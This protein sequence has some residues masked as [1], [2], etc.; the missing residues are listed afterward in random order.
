MHEAGLTLVP[1]P[2]GQKPPAGCPAGL[3]PPAA[4]CW[5][6]TNWVFHWVSVKWANELGVNVC[7]QVVCLKKFYCF[8]KGRVLPVLCCWR[9]SAAVQR[10]ALEPGGAAAAPASVCIAQELCPSGLC[11]SFGQV[12][13][14][15]VH[16]LDLESCREH[17]TQKSGYRSVALLREALCFRV[18]SVTTAGCVQDLCLLHPLRANPSHSVRD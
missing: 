11:H 18:G 6:G 10:M 15:A 7:E 1:C 16:P 12:P 9:P 8:K 14:Y 3:A 2:A 17:S 13:W 4:S 5:R